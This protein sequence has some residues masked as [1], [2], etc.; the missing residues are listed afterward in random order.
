M[1]PGDF[2]VGR[3]VIRSRGDL[4]WLLDKSA[5]IDQAIISGA[6][7]PQTTVLFVKYLKPGQVLIDVGANIGWYTILGAK[8]VG[9]LGKVIAVEAME[10]ARRVLFANV[11]LN[12]FQ[13]RV[14]IEGVCLSDKLDEPK[15]VGFNFAWPPKLRGRN[16]VPVVSLDQMVKGYIERKI[17]TCVDFIKID[18]DGYDLLVLQGAEHTIRTYRPKM[19]IEVCGYVLAGVMGGN[20]RDRC[21]EM[22]RL[23]ERYN[24][25]C[26]DEYGKIADWPILFKKF[27]MTKTSFNI[28]CLPKD[29]VSYE[30]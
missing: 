7:E 4:L 23:L 17:I 16:I 19:L 28:L 18:I 14:F 21:W 10:E 1:L 24:Y 13:D 26:W 30:N 11:V 12:K 22:V 15:D 29:E 8:I 27:D 6:W 3:T 20:P 25:V 9:N 5:L 2:S